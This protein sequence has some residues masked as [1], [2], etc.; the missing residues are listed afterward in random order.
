M[1]GWSHVAYSAFHSVGNDVPCP[2]V[3]CL[4][5]GGKVK[6]WGR[7]FFFFYLTRFGCKTVISLRSTTT[8]IVRLGLCT[9]KPPPL[10]PIGKLDSFGTLVYGVIWVGSRVKCLW[11]FDL[12]SVGWRRI[13]FCFGYLQ[14]QKDMVVPK[15]A[16]VQ[17]AQ[18]SRVCKSV[19]VGIWFC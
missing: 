7:L 8:F 14:L 17:Q 13:F 11:H 10:F 16:L 18:C 4:G 19:E 3:I 15:F 12:R 2:D 6:G 1:Y 5:A 9:A